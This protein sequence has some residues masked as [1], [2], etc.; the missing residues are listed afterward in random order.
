MQLDLLGGPTIGLSG[1]DRAPA[2][3]SQ[4]REK[5]TE[6]PMI[7]TY[8][9]TYFASSVPGGPLS[10]W[11]SRLRQRLG[12]VGSTESLLTW[13]MKATPAG[14]QLSRLVPS[15]RPTVEIAC[16]LWPTPARKG[17]NEAGN[18][19]GLV[20]IRAHAIAALWPTPAANEFEGGDPEKMWARREREKA[21]HRNGNG[22]GLT[23]GMLA[24]ASIGQNPTSSSAPT[25]KPGALNP[26]YVCWLMG[27]PAEWD[28]FAPT[29][30]PSS[31]KSRPK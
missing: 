6:P 30:M 26:A 3:R 4:S 23:I 8:G 11:E 9:P 1:L 31:R 27:F 17:D 14:R 10:L 28:A 5:V 16:G 20:A 24:T 2:S 25:E 13:R 18:S 29:A 19:V 12:T 21:K 22:F 7:G 15:M